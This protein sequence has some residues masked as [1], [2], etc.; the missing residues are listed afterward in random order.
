MAL[1]GGSL[2]RRLGLS[3]CAFFL[4]SLLVQTGCNQLEC[5]QGTREKDGKCVPVVVVGG[6]AGLACGPGTILVGNQC[7]A[8]EDIC[9]PNTKAE[10]ILDDAGVP[11]GGF[12]CKGQGGTEMPTCPDDFGPAGEF[13]VTGQVVYFIDDQGNYMKTPL[14]DANASEDSTWLGVKVYDPIEYAR[15][16]QAVPLATAQV[17]PKTGYFRVVGVP[18]PPNGSVAMAIDEL[19]AEHED[20]VAQTAT[21]YLAKAYQNLEGTQAYVVTTAQVADWTAQVGG[22]SALE[23]IGCPAPATGERDLLN[24][25]TWL[26]VFRKGDQFEPGDVVEGV[27]PRI[28]NAAGSTP[29]DPDTTFYLGID[30]NGEVQIDDPT[31]GVVWSDADGPHEWTG[32]L[33]AVI[34]PRAGV[35]QYTG[36]CGPGMERCGC[37]WKAIQ[38]GSVEGVILIQY[39]FPNSCND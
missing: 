18:E 19:D 5:A 28:T 24:C 11:T 25:G 34:R 37:L 14:A 9:G 21:P 36:N 6:D 30:S 15:D 2:M 27:E 20:I 12:V 4:G 16:P 39:M 13:C 22:P 1:Y 35:R 17:D 8:S 29:L 10:A 26:G 38:G 31:E 7:L 23:A 33:G 3:V 32:I